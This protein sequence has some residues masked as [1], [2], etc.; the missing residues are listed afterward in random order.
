MVVILQRSKE[1]LDAKPAPHGASL[2]Y[3]NALGFGKLYSSAKS[4]GRRSALENNVEAGL[5]EAIAKP[6]ERA[7]CVWTSIIAL[8]TPVSGFIHSEKR[9][10]DSSSEAR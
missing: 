9:A 1:L 10:G 6:E 2:A 5:A 3:P 4:S 7:H 8:I